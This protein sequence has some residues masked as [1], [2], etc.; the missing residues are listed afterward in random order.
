MPWRMQ[1]EIRQKAAPHVELGKVV[2]WRVRRGW[3][4]V[5]KIR[6]QS[7][8]EQGGGFKPRALEASEGGSECTELYLD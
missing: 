2:I 8:V 6:K 5:G 3:T 4:E 7:R 1:Q